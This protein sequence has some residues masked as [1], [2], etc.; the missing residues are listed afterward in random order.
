MSTGILLLILFGPFLF[1]V[2]TLPRNLND[3]VLQLL[4]TYHV[5]QILFF[6]SH[7]FSFHDINFHWNLF[8]VVTLGN[9]FHHFVKAFAACCADMFSDHNSFNFNYPSNS[10]KTSFINIH[11]ILKFVDNKSNEVLLAYDGLKLQQSIYR[12]I[13]RLLN[14]II[15]TL[16]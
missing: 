16:S 8:P 4:I 5:Y 2:M 1:Q 10:S 15:I 11:C 3:Y 13:G 7:Y 6:Y 12:I 14:L 9:F